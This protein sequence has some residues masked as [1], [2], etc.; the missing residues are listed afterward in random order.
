LEVDGV[1]KRQTYTLQ[2]PKERLVSAGFK[3]EYAYD[4]SI[5]KFDE[6]TSFSY[7]IVSKKVDS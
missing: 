6:K 7:M 5:K 4:R 2:D 1:W 3:L